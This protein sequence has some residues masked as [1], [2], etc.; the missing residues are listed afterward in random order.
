[1]TKKEYI[2]PELQVTQIHTIQMLATSVQTTGLG[3]DNLTQDDENPSG[4]AWTDAM[5]RRRRLRNQNVWDD[6]EVLEEEMEDW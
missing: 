1:M 3:D 5:S 2:Q 4:D 6:V